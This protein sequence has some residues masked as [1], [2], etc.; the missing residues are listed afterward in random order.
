[1]LIESVISS[2]A[3]STRS[4]SIVA[5]SLAL[6]SSIAVT[7]AFYALCLRSFG[8]AEMSTEPSERSFVSRVA[9]GSVPT[10]TAAFKENQQ[11]IGIGSRTPKEA[12]FFP[13]RIGC[14]QQCLYHQEKTFHSVLYFSNAPFSP[15]FR[16]Q[17]F[18]YTSSQT[19]SPSRIRAS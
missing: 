1:M 15:S 8:C 14:S 6:T 9:H 5:F 13:E 4:S 10:S 12:I 18:P 11:L 17:V 16:G 3:S 7:S 2:S 19:C